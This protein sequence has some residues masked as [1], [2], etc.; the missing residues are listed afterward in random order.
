MILFTASHKLCHRPRTEPIR[1]HT[2]RGNLLWNL[3]KKR[4]L[5]NPHSLIHASYLVLCFAHSP[6]SWGCLGLVL[7][8]LHAPWPQRQIKEIA[9]PSSVPLIRTTSPRRL[10]M[11]R[12]DG[13]SS[14]SHNTR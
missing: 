8:Q 5:L 2:Q 10:A 9:S 3:R 13:P 4:Q 1:I 14:S 6:S 7:T 11:W 12:R